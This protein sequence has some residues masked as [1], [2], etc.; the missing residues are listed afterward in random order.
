MNI[1]L[2]TGRN[3]AGKTT[4]AEHIKYNALL[5]NK[6]VIYYPFAQ[7]L[8]EDLVSYGFPWEYLQKKTQKA[9]RLMQAYGDA[10]RELD[11]QFFLRK[12]NE[13]VAAGSE[14]GVDLFISD[15]L[16]HLREINAVCELAQT[17]K[18]TITFILVKRPTLPPLTPADMEYESVSEQ[19]KIQKDI[20]SRGILQCKTASPYS[21]NIDVHTVTNDY[22]SVREFVESLSVTTIL[23]ELLN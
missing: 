1:V 22:V 8:K 7:P 20:E 5:D 9:R 3:R 19:Q 18:H 17:G 6:K 12:W 16:Y 21:L 4:L 13:R 11:S 15:D 23:A 10:R 14:H 2:I